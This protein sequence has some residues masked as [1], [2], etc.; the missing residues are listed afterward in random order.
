MDE[1]INSGI[2]SFHLS[3]KFMWYLVIT[4]WNTWY[5]LTPIIHFSVSYFWT[6]I[7]NEYEFYVTSKSEICND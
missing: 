6:A 2:G 5:M 3:F 4:H 7:V 1:K